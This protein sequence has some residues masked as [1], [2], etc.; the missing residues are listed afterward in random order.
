MRKRPSS[1]ICIYCG[2][3]TG[4][5]DHWTQ[6]RRHTYIFWHYRCWVDLERFY[7]ER[8]KKNG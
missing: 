8:R 1:G 5:A 4:P 2:K 3:P 6:T 7:D